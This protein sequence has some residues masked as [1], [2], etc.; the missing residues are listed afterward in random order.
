MKYIS[1]VIENLEYL[2]ECLSDERGSDFSVVQALSIAINIIKTEPV[3]SEK[4]FRREEIEKM[5]SLNNAVKLFE[6]VQ[7]AA[8][9]TK[10]FTCSNC[11]CKCYPMEIDFGDYNYCPNCGHK[12]IEGSEE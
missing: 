4:Y 5:I 1:D 6:E 12:M 11:G 8:H 10:D 2:K 9:W 7:K 3:K